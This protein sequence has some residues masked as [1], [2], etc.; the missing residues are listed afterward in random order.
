M[1]GGFIMAIVIAAVAIV[2][3]TPKFAEPAVGGALLPSL[4][5][6]SASPTPALAV[7]EG[8]SSKPPERLKGY[9]W[10]LR[11]GFVVQYYDWDDSGFLTLDGRRIHE[12]VAISWFE[13]A[14]VKAAHKGTVVAAGRDWAT[15]TG[16]EDPVDELVKELGRKKRRGRRLPIGVVIDDGNGYHS[17]ITGLKELTVK[18]GDKVKSGQVIGRMADN[19]CIRYELA[20]MDGDWMRV[21]QAFIERDGYPRYTRERVDPLLVFGTDTKKAPKMKR[22]APPEDPPRAGSL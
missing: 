2:I 6:P 19:C 9:K 20:R 10:P 3:A 17:I 15:Q 14:W 22:P 13:G 12:G 16:F 5:E 21:A 11:G 1:T 4:L 18:P 8:P 7:V